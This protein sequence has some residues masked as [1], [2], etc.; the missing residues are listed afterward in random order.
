MKFPSKKDDKHVGRKVIEKAIQDMVIK[1]IS[2]M[3]FVVVSGRTVVGTS[4]SIAA[5]LKG[6]R[7]VVI[8]T[9][10]NAGAITDN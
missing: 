2:H 9:L 6:R 8:V 1:L 5:A 4:E 10:N 3:K 7:G